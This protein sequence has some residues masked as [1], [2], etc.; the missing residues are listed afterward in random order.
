MGRPLSQRFFGQVPEGYGE[1]VGAIT[2]DKKGSGY[3]QANTS[4]SFGAPDLSSGTQATGNVVVTGGK[5]TAINVINAGSG[6]ENAPAVII[7]GDGSNASATSSLTITSQPGM[8]ASAFLPV[9]NGGTSAT[10]SQVLTQKGSR[11]FKVSNAQGTGVCKLVTGT[12]VAG[13]MTITATKPDTSTFLIARISEKLV[14]DASGN[15]YAW[16]F[17]TASTDPVTGL[18]KVQIQNG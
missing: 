16:G 9:E 7:E 1:S 14:Y 3:T 12:P 5:V 13:E 8:K 15:R 11:R 6:Y 17:D 4:V 2:I 18:I 10:T